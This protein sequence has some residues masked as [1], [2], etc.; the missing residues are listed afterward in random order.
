MARSKI[1]YEFIIGKPIEVSDNFQTPLRNETF[2]TIALDD[3]FD[4]NDTNAY[5]FTNHQIIFNCKLSSENSS[6]NNAMV[7]LVNLTDDVVE[8]LESNA[9]NNLVC[10]LSAGDNEQ[11]IGR[12]FAGTVTNVRDDFSTNTRR[13][14][15]VISDGGFNIKNA[16][17]VRSYPRNTSQSKIIQDLNKDMRL[18]F[19]T[20]GATEGRTLTPL[21][22]YGSTHGILTTE[23]PKL[24][25]NY[26][27]QKG[28]MNVT[29]VDTRREQEVSYI[30]KTSGLIGKVVTDQSDNKS[31]PLRKDQNSEAISF[32]CLLDYTIAPDE[33]VYVKDGKFDAAY[34]VLAV[35]FDGDYEGNSWVCQV[36]AVQT[37]WA[38]K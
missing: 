13:T 22:F 26:S 25:F 27:I 18:P 37:D 2:A 30:S 23:L 8:Y 31:S 6:A 10:T 3:F 11:G 1:L 4:E 5:K 38:I 35:T 28:V 14:Q 29:K 12:I 24:G 19:S 17:T 21:S 33:T 20:F 34:K 9:N 7:T 16:F 32:M 15:L 36:R